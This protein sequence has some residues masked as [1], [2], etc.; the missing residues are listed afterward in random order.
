MSD[1]TKNVLAVTGAASLAFV[2]IRATINEFVSRVQILP[3]NPQIDTT[4]YTNGFIQT[5]VPLTITNNNFFPIGVKNFFG[6]VTYGQTHVAN[7]SLNVGFYIPPGATRQV[8][9]NMDIP[10]LS[11]INDVTLQIQNG[12]I[13]DAVLNKL[14]LNGILTL[15]GNNINL[16][17]KLSD[18][19]IPIV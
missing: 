17:V 13:W 1:T 3:G 7:V 15:Y 16:P 14:R 5:T 18:I 4:P 8:A 11:I 12:T 9:L 6:N 10:V 2:A 19:I